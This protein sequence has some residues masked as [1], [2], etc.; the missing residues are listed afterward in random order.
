MRKTST[1]LLLLLL[2]T[3][4]SVTAQSEKHEIRATIDRMFDG[5]LAGDGDMVASTFADGAMLTSTGTRD[6]K[7]FA[8]Q[9]PASGFVSSVAQGN[10]G[11][12]E[13]IW[14]VTITVEDNLATAWMDY[15][16]LFNGEFSHCGQNTFQLARMADGAWKT[17]ALAD[18]RK[19]GRCIY[20]QNKAEESVVR[21]AL[22][23]YLSGHATG[24]GAHHSMVFN[25]VADLY[26][27][28][29]GE[30]NQR[31]SEAYIAGAS[32]MPAENESER[33][34]YIEWVDVTG[35]AAVGK[36]VLDYP[37]VYIVDYMSL[38][39]IDGRWQIV[40]KIFDIDSE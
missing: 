24:D 21:A 22:R 5:M 17:V 15:V 2:L 31:S 8:Q 38:L 7:P 14:D 23:H 13:R 26:W 33:V 40:N 34:R 11:W 36:I 16:F 10:G 1:L 12:D 39:K 27:M 37:G 20:D 6:G 18:T 29:D 19:S 4:H 28:R 3:T 25:D 35:T 32:G 30:F 9:S